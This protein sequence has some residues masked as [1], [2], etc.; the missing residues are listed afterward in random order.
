MFSENGFKATSVRAINR[1]IGM[2]DGILY[3]YFPGGKREI[4]NVLID[5]CLEKINGEVRAA[6]TTIAK[7][8]LEALIT[9][10]FALTVEIIE[11]YLFFLKIVFRERDTL[12]DDRERLYGKLVDR[13]SWLPVLLRARAAAGEIR[14]MDYEAATAVLFSQIV[15][16]VFMRM[17]GIDCPDFTSRRDRLIR[18]QIEL[19]RR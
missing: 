8:P 16:Y 13:I 11:R 15:E 4:F 3:H 9:Q 2:A 18:Y 5:E 6:E 1:E 10:Y 17:C 7:L 14:E 12:A 19:W